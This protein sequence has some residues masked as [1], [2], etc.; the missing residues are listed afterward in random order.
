MSHLGGLL[1]TMVVALMT[2]WSLVP[3]LL[4]LTTLSRALATDAF[5]VSVYR[6][7]INWINNEP[8]SAL[9]PSLVTGSN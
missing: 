1:V 9:Q 5:S 3:F 2:K 6:K 8:C 7:K 4:Q